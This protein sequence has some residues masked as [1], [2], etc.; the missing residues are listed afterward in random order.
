MK[1]HE[2]LTVD[3]WRDEVTDVIKVKV[4][5]WNDRDRTKRGVVFKVTEEELLYL[6]EGQAYPERLGAKEGFFEREGPEPSDDKME[7]LEV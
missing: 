6:G 3:W 7:D 4:C 2:R 1:N 5:I